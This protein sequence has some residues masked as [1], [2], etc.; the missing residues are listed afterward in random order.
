MMPGRFFAGKGSESVAGDYLA[1][2][3]DFALGHGIN[4]RT[5]TEGSGLTIDDLLAPPHRVGSLSMQIVGENLHAAIADPLSASIQF[6]RSM[7]LSSHGDLGIAVRGASTLIEAFEIMVHY[8]ATRTG[9][10]SI[11]LLEDGQQLLVQLIDRHTP[12]RKADLRAFFDFATLVNLMVLIRGLTAD[13]DSQSR[14]VIAV[15]W[16]EPHAFPHA[17]LVDIATVE[18]DHASLHLSIPK[19][20]QHKPILLAN[21]EIARAA[22]DKCE[23]ELRMIQAGDTVAQVSQI[24]SQADFNTLTIERVADQ[25]C[26]SVSTLKRRLQAQ[27]T[28]FLHLK[29]AERMRRAELLLG[30]EHLSIDAVA[31][32]LGYSDASNFSKAFKS[33]SGASPRAFRTELGQN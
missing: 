6:G 29:L 24:L 25:L 14:A 22:T 5:L 32:Q 11:A 8:F 28:R 30:Y 3:R 12:R 27:G 19:D 2:M 26:I 20:W 13:I 17:L 23:S 4:A 10:Q 18:F 7:A 15:D 16:S 9:S 1:A 31:T 33:W 21:E